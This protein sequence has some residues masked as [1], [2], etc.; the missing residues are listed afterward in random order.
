MLGVL[1]AVRATAE[2]QIIAAAVADALGVAGEEMLVGRP[3]F[4]PRTRRL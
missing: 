1:A 2:P 4:E 3:G